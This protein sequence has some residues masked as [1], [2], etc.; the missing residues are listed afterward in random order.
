[1]ARRMRAEVE[2]A[3]RED[4]RQI[5]SDHRVEDVEME[6]WMDLTTIAP[7]IANLCNE[8]VARSTHKLEALASPKPGHGPRKSVPDLFS[9]LQDEQNKKTR[10]G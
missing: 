6:W 3:V 7:E 2:R 9:W 4:E 10:K 8:M 1:M 5:I